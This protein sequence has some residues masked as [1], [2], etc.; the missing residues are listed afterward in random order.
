MACNEKYNLTLIPNGLRKCETI[1][2]YIDA[3]AHLENV[4]ED[5]LKR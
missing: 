3:F 4:S 1:Y 5:I 2:H